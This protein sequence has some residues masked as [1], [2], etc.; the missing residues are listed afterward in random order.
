MDDNLL[1]EILG[2]DNKKDTELSYNLDIESISSCEDLEDVIEEFNLITSISIPE[3]DLI[4]LDYYELIDYFNNNT[5]F[6]GLYYRLKLNGTKYNIEMCF[7]NLQML[8]NYYH[9]RFD[10]YKYCV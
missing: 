6:D 3:F 8:K 5:T 1:D 9:Q 4:F 2:L 7:R 10:L